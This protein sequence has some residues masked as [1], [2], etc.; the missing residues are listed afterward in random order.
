MTVSLKGSVDLSGFKIQAAHLQGTIP[1]LRACNEIIARAL[2]DI[3]PVKAAQAS[4]LLHSIR[5]VLSSLRS[6]L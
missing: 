6:D 3:A 1:D 5:E 2:A 4:K